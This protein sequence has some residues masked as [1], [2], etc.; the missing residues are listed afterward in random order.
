MIQ[1][2]VRGDDSGNA[3]LFTGRYDLLELG[4]QEV[5]SD[6]DEDRFATG[7][8]L[9]FN[10]TGQSIE[11]AGPLQSAEVRCV[12]GADVKHNVISEFTQ[13]PEREKIVIRR[14]FD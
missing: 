10:G 3:V 2:C 7:L 14:F 4:E 11:R 12:R 9:L 13:E 8:I 1:G 5:G 6:L